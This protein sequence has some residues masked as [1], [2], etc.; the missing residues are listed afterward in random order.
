M[1]LE[2]SKQAN[3]KLAIVEKRKTRLIDI[4]TITYLTCDGYVTTIHLLNQETISVSKLLKHFENEL[5]EYGFLRANHNTIVNPKNMTG[6]LSNN[7][8]TIVQ[9]NNLEIK[10][11]R[12][13][14]FLFNNHS[15]GKSEI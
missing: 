3:K 6:I 1:N 2:F 10:V 4:G 11:S 7:G 8:E 15:N 12:R 13:K 14:K 5:E 9:I